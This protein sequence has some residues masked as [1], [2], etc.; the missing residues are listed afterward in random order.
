MYKK[1]L[2]CFLMIAM[3]FTCIPSTVL[4]DSSIDLGEIDF[5]NSTNPYN[6]AL[7]PDGVFP[8][9]YDGTA[10]FLE[11]EIDISG[12]EIGRLYVYYED[13]DS[14]IEVTN[15][16]VFLYTETKDYLFFMTSDKILYMTP[17]FDV[18]LT[19]LYQSPADEVKELGNYGQ[20]LY[21][22]EDN[23]LIRFL[24]VATG[25]LDAEVMKVAVSSVFPL[26]STELLINTASD[27]YLVYDRISDTTIENLNESQ[28]MSRMNQKAIEWLVDGSTPDASIMSV[29]T[30]ASATQSNNISFP[31]SEYPANIPDN[32]QISDY[33]YY[34]PISWFHVNGQEGCNGG[35]NCKQYSETDQCEGF[36]RYAHDAY[37][38]M[39]DTS[40]GYDEWLTSKHCS[41]K[42]FHGSV[43][44]VETFFSSL[45]TGA[46]IRYSK[47]ND[48][49]PSDGAHSI[50]FLSKDSNGI[51]VYEA[52]QAYDS[53][54]TG[55]HGCGVQVRYYFYS[56][57]ANQ[58]TGAL[59]YVN[60]SFTETKTYYNSSYH[61]VGCPDCSGYVLQSHS[62]N[63]NYSYVN[64]TTHKKTHACCGGGNNMGAHTASSTYKNINDS[65]YHQVYFS[66]CYGGYKQ[67]HTF[68]NLNVC[69]KC[70]YMKSSGET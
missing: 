18:D 30:N 56:T 40:I 46:Y 33:D 27:E 21:F 22:V 64:S 26:T 68:N 32:S 31:L 44:T 20:F 70:K 5:G 67:Q 60:H 47:E 65:T 11:C 39:I 54:G 14:V 63:Y 59:R 7:P 51:W 19:V 58:Y 25:L 50:V 23:H 15:Q 57:I 4:A 28:A 37:L 43:S 29:Y 55:S 8:F 1:L 36:A 3:L 62:G 45:K 41:A 16:T 17:Y 12:C 6:Y 48:L 69:T 52:N 9:L 24:D 49:S 35:S 61:K 66:C 34:Q 53:V 42:I 2:V 13:T 38:H 10:P